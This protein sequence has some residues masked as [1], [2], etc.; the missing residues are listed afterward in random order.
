M[1]QRYK[2]LTVWE[3]SLDLVYDVYQLLP[4]FPVEERFGIT[5]QIRRCSVSISSNIAEGAGRGS[6]KD[7]VRFLYIARGS[8]NELETQLI[9]AQRLGFIAQEQISGIISKIEEIQKMI[10]GLIQHL[11]PLTDSD[12][13]NLED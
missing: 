3:K 11:N 8:T 13:S 12:T 2:K 5:Q 6:V 4:R 1:R 9:I 7:F 10:F